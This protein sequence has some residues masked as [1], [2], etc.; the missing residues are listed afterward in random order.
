MGCGGGTCLRTCLASNL[1]RAPVE[2]MASY[3]REL[4]AP[5]S[6]THLC[7]A[8]CCLYKY[9]FCSAV[10]WSFVSCMQIYTT[11]PGKSYLVT[12]I[13]AQLGGTQL[14]DLGYRNNGTVFV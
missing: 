1:A 5:F 12:Y 4:T 10:W 13:M 14:G 3:C 9:D 2:R 6:P 11:I 8:C 7:V